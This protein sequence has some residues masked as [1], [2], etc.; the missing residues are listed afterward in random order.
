VQCRSSRT[1]AETLALPLIRTAALVRVV[2]LYVRIVE[3]AVPEE[4]PEDEHCR[5]GLIRRIHVGRSNP[6]M[7][8]HMSRLL[9]P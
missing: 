4:L 8:F 6:I 2:A 3:E 5:F 9:T 7:P 1:A